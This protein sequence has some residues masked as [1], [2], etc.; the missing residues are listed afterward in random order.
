MNKIQNRE[1]SKIV[2]FSLNE[3]RY[4]LYLSAVE[5]VVRAVEITPL[6][7]VPDIVLGIINLN[8]EIMPV[9]DIRK[10][11]RLPSSVIN[12][13]DQFIITRTSKR[14]AVLVVDA[15][16][17]VY[18][19]AHHQIIDAE[20]AFPYTNYISGVTKIETN[21]ILINDLEKF[22]SLDDEKKLSEALSKGVK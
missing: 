14:H 10:L 21:I 3:P 8:G 16:I 12:L 18:D 22:L 13:E 11:F 2:V 6:P 15:V 7:K 4:A 20:D 1:S 9:I 17:G 19:I 5:R